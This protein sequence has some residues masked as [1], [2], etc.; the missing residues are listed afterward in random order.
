MHADAPA[1]GELN[2]SRAAELEAMARGRGRFLPQ[3]A[4]EG[5]TTGERCA[6]RAEIGGGIAERYAERTEIGGGMA[7][8]YPE[9]AEIGGGM[10]ERC[11]ERTEIGGGMALRS[12]ERRA[13]GAGR[14]VNLAR[15]ALTARRDSSTGTETCNDVPR[16]RRR[17][18][19]AP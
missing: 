14:C 3:G 15:R 8:R 12:G 18:G 13:M 10:A 7:E 11:S 9:R 17:T 1:D 16:S 2:G 19:G 5:A 4:S 6:E